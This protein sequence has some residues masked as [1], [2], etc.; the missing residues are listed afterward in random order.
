MELRGT[1]SN[2][3]DEVNAGSA[4][5]ADLMD[6]WHDALKCMRMGTFKLRKFSP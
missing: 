4:H 2:P 6:A 3:R 1:S 5:P